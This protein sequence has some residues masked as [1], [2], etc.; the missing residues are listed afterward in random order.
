MRL[1]TLLGIAGATLAASLAPASAQ[2][3]VQAGVLEC[4]SGQNVGKVITSAA[5][6]RCVFRDVN[7]RED[8]YVANV[9]RYGIDLGVTEKTGL[10]WAVHAPSY[11]IGRG[12]LAGHFGGV[13]A[14]ASVGLGVGAN[15]LVGGSQNAFSLQPLSLQGQVGLNAVA[16]IVDVDLIPADMRRMRR[17]HRHH[18][19]H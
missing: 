3:T 13:G 1:F 15:L 14:N 5:T 12:A 9:R 16:G 4:A 11:R 7:G 8:F 2:Q 6:Y 17:H 18:H 19:H 10:A